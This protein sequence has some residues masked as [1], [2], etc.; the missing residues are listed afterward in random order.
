MDIHVEWEYFLKEIYISILIN[1]HGMKDLYIF[2][3]IYLS[4]FYNHNEF[5]YLNHFILFSQHPNIRFFTFKLN[6]KKIILHWKKLIA[7]YQ[8]LVCSLSE[9]IFRVY[10]LTWSKYVCILFR[11][12][13]ICWYFKYWNEFSHQMHLA[14]HIG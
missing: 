14:R 8:R 12:W 13:L 10:R 4:Y 1:Q 7:Y 2:L 5:I 11:L 3:S 9:Q 6:R